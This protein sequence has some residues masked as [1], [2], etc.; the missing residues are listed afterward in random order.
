[1]FRQLGASPV[2]RLDGWV[3]TM[4]AFSVLLFRQYQEH[5]SGSPE[6][7]KYSTDQQSLSEEW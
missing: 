4:L 2:D 6:V 7:L 3:I 5:S 1:M